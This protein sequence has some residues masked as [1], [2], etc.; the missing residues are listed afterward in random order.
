[1]KGDAKLRKRNGKWED[2]RRDALIHTQRDLRRAPVPILPM[3]IPFRTAECKT[4]SQFV[5]WKQG[6]SEAEKGQSHERDRRFPR[7]NPWLLQT[8]VGP[9]ISPRRSRQTGSLLVQWSSPYRYLRSPYTSTSPLVPK[10]TR[11][12]TTTGITKRVAI[13]ARSRW[14][15]CSEVYS[16]WSILLASKA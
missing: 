9:S 13:A 6:T 15:F 5:Q 2:L 12:L 14:L 8:H 3:P 11:P 7:A 10:Y 16:G 4:R 1:M